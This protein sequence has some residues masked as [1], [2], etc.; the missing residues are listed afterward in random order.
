VIGNRSMKESHR[1]LQAGGHPAARI[2]RGSRQD[3]YVEKAGFNL[4][5]DTTPFEGLRVVQMTPRGSA[6]SAGFGT[7]I[8]DAAPG[9]VGGLYLS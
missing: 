2:R 7:G 9:S 3:L 8:T 6:C 1:G 5:V 4:D